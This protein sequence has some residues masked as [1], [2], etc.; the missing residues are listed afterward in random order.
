MSGGRGV[1]FH[2]GGGTGGHIY[3]MVAV[4]ESVD[5]IVPE[6]PRHVFLCSDRR[7]D[8]RILDEIGRERGVVPARAFGLHPKRLLPFLLGWSA[9]AGAARRFIDE[10][11]DQGPCHL[12]TTG[13]FVAPPCTSAARALG[14]ADTLLNLDAVPGKASR[15]L[16]RRAGACF[17]ALDAN[18]PAWTHVGPVVRR[19][20]R[21]P[22]EAS[23]CRQTLR[24]DPTTP[25]LFVMGGSLGAATINSMMSALT[26]A[27][28]DCLRGWQVLHLV[29]DDAQVADQQSAYDRVGASA[30]CVASLEQPG[31]AWGAATLALCRS[32]AG[33]VAEAWMN[34]V[35]CLFMPY[36][37][38]RD[39]H[40]RANAQPLAD[41]G[42]CLIER[43][44]KTPDAN[45][46]HAGA[47]LRAL[48]AEPD[49]IDGMRARL[50][51]LPD[52]DG[53]RTVAEA[54]VGAMGVGIRLGG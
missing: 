40:Q 24:L 22:E 13:G 29:G 27:H 53:A 32:G 36:P 20:A 50:H 12:L 39:E 16:A 23:V 17:S 19:A 54:I 31:L 52:L 30:R 6:P 14:V 21:V 48:L 10:S 9:A 8:A 11:R 35:P 51:D 37:Y 46:E 43:D 3:P 18:E 49:R 7:V 1:I 15:L 34:R 47:R 38:H 4:A 45:L 41:I 44:L 42:G 26:D 33:T 2:A 28:P 25:T 5:A